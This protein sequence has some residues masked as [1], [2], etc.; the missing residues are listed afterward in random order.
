MGGREALAWAG[1][2]ENLKGVNTMKRR[3]SLTLILSLLLAIS[4]LALA[5]TAAQEQEKS[6]P[7][8]SETP[9]CGQDMNGMNKR[10]DEQMGFS[11]EKTSH[12][13]R[14]MVD[15]GAIEVEAKDA[16]DKETLQQIRTHLSHIARMFAEGNFKAPMLIH[17]QTPPGVPVMQRLKAEI[18]YEFEE[19]KLGGRVR[20]TSN[21]PEAREAIY[22][23]LRF[24]IREH[25][26]G[27]SLEVSMKS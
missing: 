3:S 23:F 1:A 5:R 10:G 4:S 9:S 17:D 20:I 7:K 12:H 13:F 11:Q 2:S 19:T 25:Q 21:N 27:D 22:E 26:T 14:L 18:K 8:S 24:Q 15:G 16:N 6:K